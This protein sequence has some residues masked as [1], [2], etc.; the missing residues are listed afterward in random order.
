LRTL[1]A[2]ISHHIF[3]STTGLKASNTTATS[4]ISS[5]AK[6]FSVKT[7]DLE[8][9]PM[10]GLFRTLQ[11]D[12]WFS[13]HLRTRFQAVVVHGADVEVPSVVPAAAIVQ[14]PPDISPNGDEIVG[15]YKTSNNCLKHPVVRL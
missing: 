15:S 13:A 8:N 14:E 3:F 4:P 9:S 7:S 10:M 11:P 6:P 1:P 5:D 12:W 2:L